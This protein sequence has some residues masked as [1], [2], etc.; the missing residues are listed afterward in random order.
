MGTPF[1]ESDN[2]FR[3]TTFTFNEAI[4]HMKEQDRFPTTETIKWVDAKTG[5]P[6]YIGYSG[7]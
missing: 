7:K 6:V 1:K 2:M 3:Q 5:K 4:A